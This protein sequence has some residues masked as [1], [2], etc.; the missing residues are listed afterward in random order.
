MIYMQKLADIDSRPINLQQFHESTAFNNNMYLHVYDEFQ[1]DVSCEFTVV[2]RLLLI[3]QTFQISKH[4]DQIY[5]Q[6]SHSCRSSF[7][8]LTLSIIYKM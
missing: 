4:Q 3:Y 8:K 1:L 6:L 7:G 2:I 5:Y